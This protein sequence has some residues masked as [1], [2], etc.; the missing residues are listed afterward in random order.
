MLLISKTNSIGFLPFSD[1]LDSAKCTIRGSDSINPQSPND[2]PYSKFKSKCTTLAIWHEPILIEQMYEKMQETIA[3]ID[4][5]RSRVALLEAQID[6]RNINAAEVTELKKRIGEREREM[7]IIQE[8]I[9]SLQSQYNQ[10]D[11]VYIQDGYGIW[12]RMSLD[13]FTGL[14]KNKTSVMRRLELYNLKIKVSTL[15]KSL[16]K[17]KSLQLLILSDCVLRVRGKD[18]AE[19]QG[20]ENFRECVFDILDNCSPIL[21][22]SVLSSF[23]TTY[24]YLL[25]I[26]EINSIKPIRIFFYGARDNFVRRMKFDKYLG[27]DKYC[28]EFDVSPLPKQNVNLPSKCQAVLLKCELPDHILKTCITHFRV[29]RQRLL[30][31]NEEFSLGEFQFTEILEQIRVTKKNIEFIL[32][33]FD[34]TKFGWNTVRPPSICELDVSGVWNQVIEKTVFDSTNC[35]WVVFEKQ[36]DSSWKAR[37][38]FARNTTVDKNEIDK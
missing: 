37:Q 21:E 25:V 31:R 6:Q 7:T 38:I 16:D 19:R 14:P 2:S 30:F 27:R 9:A 23:P 17:C 10:I 3:E 5:L 1:K 20:I 15:L 4:F 28:F 11:G 18:D 32:V 8:I 24:C 35:R 29:P 34:F 22:V 36:L 26:N 12:Q 13:K 33:Q